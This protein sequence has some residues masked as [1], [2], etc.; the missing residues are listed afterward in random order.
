MR[1]K[2]PWGQSVQDLVRQWKDLA[3][4]LSKMGSRWRV[5]SREGTP[6]DSHFHCIPLA[7]VWI[8]GEQR[9]K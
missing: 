2:G 4:P 6:S 9:W 5:S 3:F 7:A 8:A 1:T